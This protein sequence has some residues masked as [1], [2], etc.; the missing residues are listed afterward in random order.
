MIRL[1][2]PQQFWDELNRVERIHIRVTVFANDIHMA[3]Q[4]S[5]D[6]TT[7]ALAY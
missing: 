2:H 3:A 1:H 4:V 7:A 5:W 6:D